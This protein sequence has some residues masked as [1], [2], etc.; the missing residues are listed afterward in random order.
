MEIE[1][2]PSTPEPGPSQDVSPSASPSPGDRRKSGRVTRKPDL[3]SQSYSAPNGATAGGAKRKR[4]ATGEEEND[5]E[6]EDEED[7][8]ETESEDID[9]QD[10]DEEELREKKRAARKAAAKRGAAGTKSKAKSQG[11][12]SAKKPKV[13]GN[14][15]GSQLALRPAANGAKPASRPRKPKVRPSLAAG[16]TGLYAEVFGKGR[17]PETVAAD[18]LT[19]YHQEP[20]IAM[21]DMINLVLRCSGADVEVTDQDI[22]DPDHIAPRVRDLENQYHDQGI[23]EYPLVSKSRKYRSFQLIL[24]NFY[25]ALMQTFHHSSALYDEKIMYENLHSWLSSLSSCHCRPFRHTATVIALTNMGA[26]CDIA[27]EVITSVSSSRKQLE[28]EKKKKTVNKGR[29]EAIKS[30]I[31][32]GENKLETI[33]DHLKDGVNIFFVNRYRDVEPK[34]RAESVAALGRWMRTYKEYFFEGQF[35]RYCGWITS[36]SDVHTRS[37]ALRQLISV[38]SNKDNIAGART[39]TERFRHRFVEIAAH[40]ADVGVRILAIEL[41]DLIREAGLMEPADID[42][43]GKLIFDSDARVRKAAG[44]FFVANVHDVFDSNVEEVADEVNEMFGDEDEDEDEFES[45]KRSWIKFK[46][47]VDI[48]QAYDVPSETPDQPSLTPRDTLS[49]ISMDSRFVLATEA[50]SPHFEELESWQSLAGYLLYDH[51]QIPSEQRDGDNSGAVKKLYKMEEGQEVIL[52]EVLCCAVKLRIL[53]VAKSDVDKRGRRVK[54]LTDRI[55]ELQ[56]EIAHGL[57]QII[58][59]LLNK[60]GSTP[61]AASAVL[62]LEHLVDLDKIQDLQKD[63]AAYTSLLNDINKQFLTHSDQ[64]VLAEASVAFLH[65]KSSD[66]MREALEGKIQELWDDVMDTLHRLSHRKEVLSDSPISLPVLNELI[67]TVTR[68]S[69]LS[70]VTDCTHILETAPSSR[71]RGR[72]TDQAEAPFNILLH[73][74]QRGLRGETMGAED[75]DEEARAEIEVVIGSI[76]ILLFYFMWKVQNLRAALEAGKAKFSTAYFE[77]LTKSRETFVDTLVDIM[78]ARS[79]LDEV[80]FSA[81]TTL[82]DLQTLFGTIRHAGLNVGNDEEDMILQTQSLVHE[83]GSDVQDLITKIHGN[84]L[85]TY[86][87]KSGM[88]FEPAEDDAPASDSELER[89]PMDEEEEFG[90]EKQALAS[91]RLRSKIVAEQRLC[92]LTGKIVLAIIGRILDASGSKSGH[93]KK[94]LLKQKSQYGPNYREV[95]VFLEDRAPKRAAPRA[96]QSKSKHAAS[97]PDKPAAGAAKRAGEHKSTERVDEESDADDSPVEDNDEELEEDN[98]DQDEDNENENENPATPE[99]DEDEIMGD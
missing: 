38:Y 51:S 91:E 4:A 9:D 31:Q 66:D 71:S 42:T 37:I 33:D 41:L 3:Y 43:V 93:L 75:D 19:K 18:W 49:G 97:G 52:L 96:A 74:V 58:P 67:N 63:A 88:A 78:E 29:V 17:N 6:R 89:E 23:T 14:G 62:R 15:I 8:S 48:L 16:E 61:E 35:L 84:A 95:L 47:L 76:R 11:S 98:I 99:P 13:A 2:R 12:R 5:E 54:A 92:E 50:I 82:L 7:A 90:L 27:R 85:R 86:A 30:A 25:T 10:P 94:K 44:H 79:G 20:V 72:S 68:I 24:E 39:F 34:I 70:G 22:E 36:D 65:A 45:P 55:P 21:R 77:A 32:E 28:T 81:T 40:D 64:D 87:K 56:E 26:L 83:I 57:A 60:F 1:S 59:Q 73:L 80:R 53:E 69:N 46:C